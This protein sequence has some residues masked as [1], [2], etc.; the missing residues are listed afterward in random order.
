MLAFPN[1]WPHLSDGDCSA[2]C[3]VSDC[4]EAE[5]AERTAGDSDSSTSLC[6]PLA[7]RCGTQ[8]N[9]YNCK[10]H[11]LVFRREL[12]DG[13]QQHLSGSGRIISKP[14]T[15]TLEG[16]RIFKYLRWCLV[17]LIDPR[18]T[19]RSRSSSLWPSGFPSRDGDLSDPCRTRRCRASGSIGQ[20]EAGSA[21]KPMFEAR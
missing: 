12:R 14:D 5:L 16:P 10:Q 20:R 1:H 4:R 19:L 13:M 18:S 21:F 7:F 3:I 15:S 6:R 17:C 8:P 11:P 2:I 9:H